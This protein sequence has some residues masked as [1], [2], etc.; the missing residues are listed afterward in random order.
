M[1]SA[2]NPGIGPFRPLRLGSSRASRRKRRALSR[3][4]RASAKAEV[5]VIDNGGRT[6]EACVGDLV[7][8]EADLVH[9][10]GMVIWG[11]LRDTQERLRIGMPTFSMGSFPSGLRRVDRRSVDDLAGAQIGE[12]RVDGGD[13]AAADGDGILFLP[14]EQGDT[15]ACAADDI[16]RMEQGCAEAMCAGT[17]LASSCIWTP[18]GRT[19]I[20]IP[21]W[22]SATS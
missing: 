17:S 3:C 5:L 4:D 9:L 14:V 16:K 7:A 21:T 11:L 8:L 15:I 10:S 18:I 13:I 20:V 12:W 22:I 1:R 19:S 6:D 2:E